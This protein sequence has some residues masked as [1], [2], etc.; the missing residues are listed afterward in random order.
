MEGYYRLTREFT[1]NPSIP[2]QVGRGLALEP[3]IRQRGRPYLNSGLDRLV[4]SIKIILSTRKGSRFFNP[5]FG[6]HLH[7][8]LFEPN[9][10]VKRLDACMFAKQALQ[11]WEPRIEVTDVE[12]TKDQQYGK[13]SLIIR[14][15][16]IG[17]GGEHSI[18]FDLTAEAE[19][20]GY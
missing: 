10:Y 5:S 15:R 14:F 18:P 3:F 4:Q 1:R 2:E 19:T 16:I 9:V 6:S 11:E 13:V 8:L 7:S 12:A 17:D 20:N